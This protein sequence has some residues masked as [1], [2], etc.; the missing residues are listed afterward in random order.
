MEHGDLCTDASARTIREPQVGRYD[1]RIVGRTT[2]EA[3]KEAYQVAPQLSFEAYKALP[4]ADGGSVVTEAAANQRMHP[5]ARVR[6]G[7]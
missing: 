5:A 4:L 7:G 3:Q 1:P 6:G 2:V